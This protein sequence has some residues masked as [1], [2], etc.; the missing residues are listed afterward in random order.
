[1]PPTLSTP[2]NSLLRGGFLGRYS[3]MIIFTSGLPND[4]DM[5]KALGDGTYPLPLFT[6]ACFIGVVERGGIGGRGR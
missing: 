4:Q 2:R 6:D 5:I 3:D 1:M